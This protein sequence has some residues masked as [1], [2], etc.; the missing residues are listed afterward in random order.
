MTLTLKYGALCDDT[1]RNGLTGI[2]SKLP[3][4]KIIHVY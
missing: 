1:R 2:L 3:K 4:I